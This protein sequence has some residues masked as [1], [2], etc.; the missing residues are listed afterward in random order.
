ML[1]IMSGV[2][3]RFYKWGAEG[4]GE[5]RCLEVSEFYEFLLAIGLFFMTLK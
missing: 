5:G 1:S 4:K 2:Q 3:T